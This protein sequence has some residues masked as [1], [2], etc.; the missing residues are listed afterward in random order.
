MW[1]LKKGHNELLSRTESNCTE[2]GK[3]DFSSFSLFL[4]E[5]SPEGAMDAQPLS[6]K[7]TRIHLC[8][9]EFISNKFFGF[10]FLVFLGMHP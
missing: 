3:H 7:P 5:A 2:P 9:S 8:C 10:C 1:N 4:L 6:T